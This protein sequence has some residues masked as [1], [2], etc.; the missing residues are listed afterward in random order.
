MVNDGIIGRSAKV[1]TIVEKLGIEGWDW[2]KKIREIEEKKTAGFMEDIIA[3]RPI[4]SFP[5]RHGGFRLRYGRA[6]NTGL[7]AIGVHPV[8]MKVLQHFIAAGTQLRIE[9][10]GKAGVVLPVDTIE[11]PLVRLKDG[12]VVRVSLQNFEQIE[13]VI[14]KILFLGDVLIGFGDFLY[15]N[16]PLLP[17]GFTE[18][19][20]H[21]ELRAAIEHNFGSKMKE[22]A[23]DLRIPVCRLKALLNKPFEEKPT[24]KEA[25]ALASAFHIPLHP[26]FTFFWSNISSDELLALRKWVL[27]SQFQVKDEVICEITGVLDTSIKGVLER[28]GLPHKVFE[29]GLRIENDEAYALAFCVGLRVPKSK[30]LPTGSVLK[31]DHP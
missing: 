9:G 7:A 26:L 1:W 20:W 31:I 8:T 18:E 25:I 2:L 28:I 13:S 23:V 30:G 3:G 21:E 19:W 5:S 11:P 16:K 24:A 15:N 14:D 4:L 29:R 27:T 6:R 22:A 17:S 10:P 12:S